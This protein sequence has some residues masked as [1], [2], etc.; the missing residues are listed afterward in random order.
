[1][2]GTVTYDGFEAKINWE[3]TP[4]AATSWYTP[5]AM[6]AAGPTLTMKYADNLTAG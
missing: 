3:L 2:Q 1:V 6:T 5:A 4:P